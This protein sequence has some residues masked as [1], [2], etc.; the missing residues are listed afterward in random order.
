MKPTIK[1]RNVLFPFWMLLLLPQFWFVVIPGNFLIDSLVLL[2][3]MLIFKI[4]HKKHFFLTHIFKIFAFGM[5]SDIVGSAYMLIMMIGFEVGS[6]GDEPHLTVPA[7]LISTVLIFLLNYFLTFR[8]SEH[9][10]R[11]PMALTFAIVTAPYTFLI[12]SSLLYG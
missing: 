2:I 6:M 3:L 9:K 11:L 7:L 1:L 4:E 10:L 8:K 5:L 12:P